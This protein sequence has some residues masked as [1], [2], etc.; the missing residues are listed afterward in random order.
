MTRYMEELLTYLPNPQTQPP[1]QTT[2]EG[3]QAVLA[4]PPLTEQSR[5]TL[6]FLHGVNKAEFQEQNDLYKYVT[7]LLDETVKN[8][9]YEAYL[10][11]N[12]EYLTKSQLRGLLKK[13]LLSR[14]NEYQ[15]DIER[16]W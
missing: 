15:G 2:F 7:D 13:Y 4:G 6:N 3:L 11:K 5:L 16:V 1:T 8:K 14:L 12:Y 9:L 10:T